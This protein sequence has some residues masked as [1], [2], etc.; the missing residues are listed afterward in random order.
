MANLYIMCGVPGSGKSTWAKKHIR[1]HK[2]KHISRDKIR[3]SM[4]K[5]NEEYFSKEDE[6]VKE[7][8]KKINESLADDHFTFA[9][10]THLTPAARKKVLSNIHGYEKVYAIEMD[11]PLCVALERNELR[12]GTR[13]YVP[14]SVIRRMWEQFESPTCAEGFAEIYRVDKDG[15]FHIIK[16]V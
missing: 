13:A 14:R 5:E 6:V 9:D 11:V 2:G 10:A 8:Y 1:S 3:F 7:F 15:K 16:E 12:K 4:I